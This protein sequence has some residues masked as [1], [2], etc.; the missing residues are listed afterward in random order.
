MG[1]G[2]FLNFFEN[3]IHHKLFKSKTEFL[4]TFS[5]G[6]CKWYKAGN[7]KHPFGLRGMVSLNFHF[8]SYGKPKKGCADE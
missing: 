4:K 3:L 7:C 8:C 2:I 6:K 5:C 1:R